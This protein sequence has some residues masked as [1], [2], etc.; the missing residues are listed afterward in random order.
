MSQQK[1][2][3]MAFNGDFDIIGE[4][5]EAKMVLKAFIDKK[6]TLLLPVIWTCITVG[7]YFN[8][9][10]EH[11]CFALGVIAFLWLFLITGQVNVGEFILY[12][13]PVG[14]IT[15]T[16]SGMLMDRLRVNYKVSLGIFTA[17][18]IFLLFLFF[19]KDF[20]SIQ[21]LQ[22]KHGS[23]FAPIF[24]AAN[25]ALYISIVFSLVG[26]LIAKLEKRF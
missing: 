15:M 19:I 22:A 18:F 20:R 9:G 2:N 25:I 26:Q 5:R 24:S 21:A 12:L 8:S 4:A 11:G 23:V 17:G 16:I 14:I 13:L 6:Y 1:I 7:S 10:D 3:V